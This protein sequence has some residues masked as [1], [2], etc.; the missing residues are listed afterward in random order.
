[1]AGS[2]LIAT[3]TDLVLSGRELEERRCDFVRVLVLVDTT[4]PKGLVLPVRD[5][6]DPRLPTAEVR[7]FAAG[8][9]ADL[10][11]PEPPDVCVAILGG[12]E[13][14]VVAGV[15]ELAAAGVP[16]ALVCES[17][18]DVPGL[19]LGATAAGRVSIIA[20]TSP[21]VLVDRLAEWLVDATDK[22]IALAANFPFCRRAKVSSLINEYAMVNAVDT[23]KRGEGPLLGPA[24]ANQA[25]L[26]LAI[27]AVN[28][29][30]LA[31]GRIPEVLSAIGA[32]IG[33]RMVADRA[34][35]KV[36]L[37]GRAAKV[38]LGYLGTQATGLSLQHSF[39]LREQRE[40]EREA[41]V[42]R[43][44]VADR[45]AGAARSIAHGQWR[46][47]QVARSSAPR[48]RHDGRADGD[49]SAPVGGGKLLT[50]GPDGDYLVLEQEASR[51]DER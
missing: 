41:G 8:S 26:A 45:L 25:R 32:G 11:A 42:R 2:S 21:E 31:L 40:A 15:S 18:L 10:L 28:G 33:S 4:A 27:A 37:L 5:S 16:V 34:L 20:A 49:V 35:G 12:E 51:E 30:P 46:D 39:D 13:E 24:V 17:A 48:G 1:M 19:P 50:S 44:S 14:A 7:V 22:G 29:Q 9:P 47:G 23:A 3:T 6:L 43:P 38:G 36:P